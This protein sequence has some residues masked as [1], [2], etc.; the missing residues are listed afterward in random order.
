MANR[1]LHVERQLP[2]NDRELWA[3]YVRQALP[4]VGLESREADL[5]ER[6]RQARLLAVA[7]L[8]AVGEDALADSLGL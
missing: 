3:E 5:V 2:R 6:R 7:A 4:R 8:R 1:A